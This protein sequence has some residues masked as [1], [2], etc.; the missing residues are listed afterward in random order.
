MILS[1]EEY[2]IEHFGAITIEYPPDHAN[3]NLVGP[4]P[5]SV[6]SNAVQPY[7]RIPLHWNHSP[8]ISGAFSGSGSSH[9][10]SDPDN[11]VTSND[12][13]IDSIMDNTLRFHMF[14][15]DLLEPT[16]LYSKLEVLY[17]S[18]IKE[19]S[20]IKPNVLSDIN[21][22]Y[23][24]IDIETITEPAPGMVSH[25]W[26]Q[27][28]DPWEAGE[29]DVTI[30]DED[31]SLIKFLGLDIKTLNGIYYKIDLSEILY[32][33]IK[34]EKGVGKTSTASKLAED[35]ISVIDDNITEYD[36][37]YNDG[38]FGM[39]SDDIEILESLGDY[40]L[41]LLKLIFTIGVE[42]VF[43][44]N[45]NNKIDKLRKV[46]KEFKE[47]YKNKVGKEVIK[48]REEMRDDLEKLFNFK[49]KFLL[50]SYI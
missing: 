21:E 10:G 39:I 17:D 15:V 43:D 31:G 18:I 7:G 34:Y 3:P 16:G 38:G 30:N 47:F 42:I 4:K 13:N 23:L 50:R 9:F 27:P 35:M 20:E 11:E 37:S 44:K 49:S 2:I 19:I 25:D 46:Q 32:E 12:S 24:S 45:D 1:F 36:E 48:K 33:F 8:Y 22:G 29:Y 40:N 6:G 14:K 5:L 28:D 41:A 26:E